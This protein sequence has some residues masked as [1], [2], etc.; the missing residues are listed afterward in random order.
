[1]SGLDSDDEYEIEEDN[2]DY[3]ESDPLPSDIDLNFC[4]MRKFPSNEY[5]T[6]KERGRS[7]GNGYGG[8][9][10]GRGY[11]HFLWLDFGVQ[12]VFVLEYVEVRGNTMQSIY[13]TE[14]NVN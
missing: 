13:A 2:K 4:K 10:G 11:S 14:Q 9:S 6:W 3:D 5:A 1:M 7:Y 12:I 8:G